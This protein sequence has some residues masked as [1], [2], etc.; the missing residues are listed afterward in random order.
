MFNKALAIAPN[1][2]EAVVGLAK[3]CL[4]E[5]QLN[6]AVY[7]LLKAAEL[8]PNSVKVHYLLGHTLMREGRKLDAEAELAKAETL[9]H[10]QPENGPEAEAGA[11]FL[12]SWPVLNNDLQVEHRQ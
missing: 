8:E 6:L 4:V 10:S 1:M 3:A 7:H 2:T 12:P 11:M 9:R 5:G